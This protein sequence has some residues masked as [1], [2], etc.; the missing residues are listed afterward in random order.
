MSQPRYLGNPAPPR[1]H[2]A[3]RS[4]CNRRPP[5]RGTDRPTLPTRQRSAEVPASKSTSTDPQK[6]PP[7]ECHETGP[8]PS[9]HTHPSADHPHNHPP[10][11]AAPGRDT[12]Q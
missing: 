6:A 9:L 1:F 4:P 5:D 7:L 12:E 3:R 10:P 11:P 8:V 2:T